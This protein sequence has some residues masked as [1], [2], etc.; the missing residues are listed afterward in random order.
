MIRDILRKILIESENIDFSK[1]FED[2]IKN[3]LQLKQL[4]KV[5]FGSE[6]VVYSTGKN[7]IRISTFPPSQTILDRIN[8]RSDVVVNYYA[9][10]KIKIPPKILK[11]NNF[12]GDYMHLY[13]N[14]YDIYTK[15]KSIHNIYV[16]YLIME[17]VEPLTD[18]H[19]K[20]IYSVTR[21]LAEHF[22][23]ELY[24]NIEPLDIFEQLTRE[25]MKEAFRIIK[26]DQDEE[27]YDDFV[28]LYTIYNYLKKNGL[29]IKD[30]HIN[31]VGFDMD[32]KLKI[33]DVD[34][35]HNKEEGKVKNV[36]EQNL[37]NNTY[38]INISDIKVEKEMELIDT[39]YPLEIIKSIKNGKM[40]LDKARVEGMIK[41]IKNGKK[42][43]PLE[44][45]RENILKDGHH[46]YMAYK[47]A[48]KDIVT[49]FYENM[50]SD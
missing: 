50:N 4:N 6:A 26:T 9:A 47:L 24:P 20:K 41:S 37:N 46:R 30:F 22:K 18:E 43:P 19:V 33:Y 44:L 39:K 48:G 13:A 38:L 42:L 17:S 40:P 8:K 16:Y 3:T 29:S 32:F 2:H 34:T 14:L 45:K 11:L 1:L 36:F 28:E 10:G 12:E 35:L 5:G 31:Q 23:L 7:I 25:E 21:Y 15:K 49:F 27:S